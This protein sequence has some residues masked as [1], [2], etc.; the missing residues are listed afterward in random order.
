MCANPRIEDDISWFKVWA[1]R[2]SIL[3][4]SFYSIVFSRDTVVMKDCCI[5]PKEVLEVKRADGDLLTFVE[6]ENKVSGWVLRVFVLLSA[7]VL[8]VS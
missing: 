8:E 5:S 3:S 7:V 1:V 4:I 2:S 6:T